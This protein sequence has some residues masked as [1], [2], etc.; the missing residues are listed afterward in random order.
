MDP[1]SKYTSIMS[2]SAP[3]NPIP[4]LGFAY[5]NRSS[6]QEIYKDECVGIHASMRVSFCVSATQRKMGSKLL[7]VSPYQG[8]S[9]KIVSLQLLGRTLSLP[10]QTPPLQ[11]NWPHLRHSISHILL[12][13]ERAVSIFDKI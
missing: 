11:G 5:C 6:D 7:L 13:R 3:G 1:A 12:R 8:I 4:E 2:S 9:Q 10:S